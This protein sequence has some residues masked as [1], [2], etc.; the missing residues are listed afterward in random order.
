MND[1]PLWLK[2]LIAVALVSALAG[3]V[4]SLSHLF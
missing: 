2:A 3:F 1:F 4:W